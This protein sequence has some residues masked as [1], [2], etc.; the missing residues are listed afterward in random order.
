M[1]KDDDSSIYLSGKGYPLFEDTI[2]MVIKIR[3]VPINGFPV[4]HIFLNFF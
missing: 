2:W 4:S 3:A 1:R